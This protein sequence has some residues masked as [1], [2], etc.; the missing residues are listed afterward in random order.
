MAEYG[1][2]GLWGF[3]DSPQGP[4]RHAMLEYTALDLPDELRQGFARWIQR[5]ED[6]NLSQQLDHEAFNAEGLRLARQLKDYLGTNCYIEYQGESADGGL[7]P[8]ILLD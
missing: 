6:E 1:S 3:R 8:S 5:Y 2:S 7:L 4:F